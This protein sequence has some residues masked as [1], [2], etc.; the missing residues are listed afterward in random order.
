MR[1]VSLLPSTFGEKRH[2]ISGDTS[3]LLADIPF[4]LN[5]S[6]RT[7]MPEGNVLSSTMH[8][9][10]ASGTRLKVRQPAGFVIRI[11]SS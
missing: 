7:K 8:P 4:N 11:D 1:L 10:M 5:L 6:K 2:I 3:D 9:D